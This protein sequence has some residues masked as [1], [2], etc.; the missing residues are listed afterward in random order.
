MCVVYLCVPAWVL[1]LH[2]VLLLVRGASSAAVAPHLVGSDAE[3]S[4]SA[5][6]SPQS[7]LAALL[8]IQ[9]TVK[10]ALASPASVPVHAPDDSQ[11]VTPKADQSPTGA[12]RGRMS[13]RLNSRLRHLDASEEHGNC[14]SVSRND[15]LSSHYRRSQPKWSDVRSPTAVMTT[16]QTCCP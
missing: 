15:S 13:V 4:S 12:C 8:A 10:T 7:V 6:S 9:S 1:L 3:S 5:A 14:S 2:A 11:M 16:Q